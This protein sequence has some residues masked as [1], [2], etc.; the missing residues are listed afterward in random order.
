MITTIITINIVISCLCLYTVKQLIIL[1]KI[2]NQFAR[3]FTLL[4]RQSRYL[5]KSTS[6]FCLLRE[7]NADHIKNKYER[8]NWQLQQM[9]KFLALL[10]LGTMIYLRRQKKY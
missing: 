3:E 7:K 10:N 4:E 2:V 9:Q 5:L 8:L 6:R 1:T